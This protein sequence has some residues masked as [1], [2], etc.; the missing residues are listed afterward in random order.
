MPLKNQLFILLFFL[1]AC[2]GSSHDGT[3]TSIQGEDLY[4]LALADLKAF[5][6]KVAVDGKTTYEQANSIVTWYAQNFDWT[7]TDYKKRTVRDILERKGGNC[8]ELAMVTTA[9][10]EALNMKMRKVREINIHVDNPSR[11]NRAEQKV[12]DNGPKASVFGRRHNDHVWIE[13]YDE[14]TKSWFPADPSL[15]IAGKKEWLEARLGFGERY[16]LDPTSTDMIAPFA[17]FAMDDNNNIVENRTRHYIIE[18]FNE[19]YT[20][21]LQK[22]TAW[23]EWTELINYLDDKARGAFTGTTNLHKYGDEIARLVE[24]YE[25]LKTEFITLHNNS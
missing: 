5:A 4:Q 25:L 1:I 8:N 10:M 19:V 13:I 23:N 11:Q 15:G 3:D 18:G 2:Q 21:E 14:A 22:L 24:L 7:A 6:E 17:V 9:T 16:T 12:R 20:Y